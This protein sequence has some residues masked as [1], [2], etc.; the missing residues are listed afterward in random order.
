MS[1]LSI[2]VGAGLAIARAD[3]R[4][5]LAGAARAAGAALDGAAVFLAF[6]LN[7]AAPHL[8]KVVGNALFVR[9]DGPT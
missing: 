2:T 5:R 3:A 9:G 6:G 7:V 1:R 8:V 4:D